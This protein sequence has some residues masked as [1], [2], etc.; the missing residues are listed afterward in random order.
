MNH[1]CGPTRLIGRTKDLEFIGFHLRSPAGAP[2]LLSG[3][4][5]LGK[6]ALLEEAAAHL[7]REGSRVLWASGVRFETD[8]GYAGL[9][10]LLLPLLDSFDRLDPVHRDALRVAVGI[11]AGP[12][13][14]RL[15]TSTAVLLLLRA[16]AEDTPL[17]LVVD[18]IP[19]LDRATVSVLGFV[20]RRLVGSRI[21]FLAV[22]RTGTGGFLE[23]GGP[24]EHRLR[25]LD[26]ASSAALLDHWY[27]RISPAVRRRVAA[28][29]RGNPLA[30]VELPAALD[31]DQRESR[32]AV[33]TELPLGERLQEVFAAGVTDLP[34]ATRELLLIAALDGTGDLATV[35]AAAGRPVLVDLGVAERTRLVRISGFPRRLT[36][37][38]PL[39]GS[40]AVARALTADRRAVHQALAGALTGQPERRAWHFG[41]ARATPDETVAA[42]LQQAARLRLARGDVFGAVAPGTRRRVRRGGRAHPGGRTQPAP[43]RREPAAG[44]GG[45][46]RC[47]L[48]R[49]TGGRRP[50][51]GPRTPRRPR[52]EATVARGSGLR[53]S[54][55]QR[56][57]RHRHRAPAADRRDRSG[58][59]PLGRPRQRPRRGPVQPGHPLLLQRRPAQVAAAAPG[60]GPAR[61]R[62]A[63]AAAGVRRDTRRPR[64]HRSPG[65][66][67]P[68]R[69][70]VRRRVPSDAGGPR[71]RLRPR[72]TRTAWPA[73][74]RRRTAWSS[75]AVRVPLRSAD[76]WR[77][78]CT[79][80][81]TGTAPATGARP[82]AWRR[83][84]WH[85]ARNTATAPSAASSSTCERSWP[86]PA[87]MP[88]PASG[89]PRRWCGGRHPGVPTASGPSPTTPGAWPLSAAATSSPPT[90]TPVP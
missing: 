42:Q 14:S 43:R 1:P 41:E 27:P 81:S 7:R 56:R 19:W 18:D 83:R 39:I 40:A 30:L 11:G 61:P 38:H 78:W 73:Y 67:G 66:A 35:E 16:V 29:A 64:A 62:A 4:A 48:R 71:R 86:P 15:L 54:P 47:R 12:S 28:P 21:G 60:P 69:A 52:R 76:T 63:R 57:G 37:Q 89:W 13:P 34:A 53:P 46:H 44:R 26:D 31:A 33:P 9:N 58:G 22:C 70:A 36:F 50:A 8:I 2:L 20:S 17:C 49:R 85:C 3:E 59:P 6:T 77:P 74:D 80:A 51:P 88:I 72:S 24:V 82:C 90:A 84:A 75:R 55:A 65:A 68:A 79:C 5:G 23:S 25:P 10:L 45:L 87:V 32:A